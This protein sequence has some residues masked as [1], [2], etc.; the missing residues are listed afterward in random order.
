MGIAP[1]SNSV[2]KQD[3]RY[4]SYRGKCYNWVES[5]N[6]DLVTICGGVNEAKQFKRT[7]TVN[8]YALALKNKLKQNG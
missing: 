5:F 1:K 8:D 6:E 4:H 3:I 2:S 7:A